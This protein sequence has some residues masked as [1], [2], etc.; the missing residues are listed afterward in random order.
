MIQTIYSLNFPN[1]Q[2]I[3][4]YLNESTNFLNKMPWTKRKLFAR[5]IAHD[6]GN[7]TID[8]ASLLLRL[9][10]IKIP[11]PKTNHHHPLKT[12]SLVTEEI[13]P[14]QRRISDRL[15][16]GK[17]SHQPE[18]FDAIQTLRMISSLSYNK[19]PPTPSQL[20]CEFPENKLELTA[21]I[22]QK[23]ANNRLNRI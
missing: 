11:N 12:S 22:L 6:L 14:S 19:K 23:C 16:K 15:S 2:K 4:D 21:V 9:K 3:F 18:N 8:N 13:P 17:P 10:E 1:E 5:A 7:S 20:H